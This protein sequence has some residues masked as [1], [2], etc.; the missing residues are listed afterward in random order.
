MGFGQPARHHSLRRIINNPKVQELH[1]RIG[2]R[3]ESASKPAASFL[4]PADT[5]A[6]KQKAGSLPSFVVA[7]DSDS[8]ST[9][10]DDGYPGAYVGYLTSVA[11]AIRLDEL[12]AAHNS[13]TG[14]TP[15]NFRKLK[16]TQSSEATLPGIGIVLDD[17]EDETES[18]RRAL[19]EMMGSQDPIGDGKETLLKTYEAIVD[20]RF[21]Q[22]TGL[23]CPF[24]N[25]QSQCGAQGA[26]YVLNAGCYKCN[27]SEKKRLHSTD[28]LR[29]SD[30][31]RAGSHSNAF[32]ETAE[33]LQKLTLLNVLR[34]MERINALGA[35]KQIA[36]IIDGPLSVPGLVASSR[37]F[38]EAELQ[39]LNALVKKA[40]DSDLLIVG[41]EKSGR[42]VNHFE[43][44]ER[45]HQKQHGS[46]FP[47]GSL[48]LPDNDYIRKNIIP[49]KKTFGESSSF[50]RR[51]LYRNVHAVNMVASVPFLR[52]GDRNIDQK[53]APDQFPRLPDVLN[54]LDAIWSRR[55]ENGVMPLIIAHAEA[56][57]PLHLGNKV[58][59]KLLSEAAGLNKQPRP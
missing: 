52:P 35:A 6:L 41:I 39:R 34:H 11:V 5:L 36:F 50:G 14:I 47:R 9:E 32:A 44:I 31:L 56:A 13:G 37:P 57:I 25:D 3:P 16:K 17:C 28:W 18:F 1:K 59:T 7:L 42:F 23:K 21:N 55:Y 30:G 33:F 19:Y 22:P 38:I 8:D 46:E 26:D 15:E 45:E 29:L 4:S 43:R 51:L 53:A 40:T 49:G 12:T 10:W 48:L 24:D 2:R 58:F 27:C 20:G 54:L